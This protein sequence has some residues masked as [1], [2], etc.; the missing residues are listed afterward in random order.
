MGKFKE[1]DE[2]IITNKDS[3]AEIQSLLSKGIIKNIAP[4]IYTPKLDDE[5]GELI[6]RNLF[7]IIS[8]KY[9]TAVIS[10]RSAFELSPFQGHIFASYNYTV[11]IPLP[12]VTISLLKG[13]GAI[14]GDMNILGATI[15]QQERALLENLEISRGNPSKCLSKEQIEEK[16]DM[17][18]MTRGEAYLNEIRDKARV[19]SQKL[20][21]Q[22]EFTILDSMI[23]AMLKTRTPKNLKSDVA[24][25]RV[26]NTPH[27][28]NRIKLFE[29][30]FVKL[31]NMSF[32][33][34]PDKNITP[35]SYRL[36]SFFESYFSNYIEGT[37]FPVDEAKKI[38]DTGIP[39]ATR[40]NDSHDILGTYKIVSDK[41]GL[42]RTP[43]DADEFILMLKERHKILLSSRV[44]LLP[45]TFKELTN[46][47]GNTVFVEPYLVD[48]TLRKGFEFYNAL[49]DPFSKAAFMMFMIA[50]VHPFN[51]GNG[52]ISRVF[53]NSELTKESQS[54][55]LITTFFR[56][57]Y[58]LALK[59][60]TN[61]HEP[62][63]YIRM[64][65]KAQIN[66]SQV[67][68]EDF[69]K[70][71]QF[72]NSKHAFEEPGSFIIP[73]NTYS[74]DK[75][76]SENKLQSQSDKEGITG[77]IEKENLAF[78]YI[79]I[80]DMPSLGRLQK[81]GFKPSELF[82]SDICQ[83]STFSDETK[84]T[85]LTILGVENPALRLNNE[86]KELNSPAKIKET[87]NKKVER[88]VDSNDK[89]L[90]ADLGNKK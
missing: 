4:E 47:A 52:R 26:N 56:D 29:K 57:D 8:A 37:K 71:V 23:G 48:G 61:Q 24:K 18:I 80:N 87:P 63:I 39:M 14:E 77:Q 15:S 10:H 78:S 64:L 38:I 5:P 21:M 40:V 17:F 16:L 50:E 2:I 76:K 60:L 1:Y 43:K 58:M 28:N 59:K 3:Y 81:E 79:K 35:V 41:S 75:E 54:K 45:G 90:G 46:M 53:M 85:A 68:G 83:S 7:Q 70:V 62:D 74:L 32:E 86:L 84:I 6:R 55:I 88:R 44:D 12:G 65:Q 31:Y 20:S 11:K 51:D 73:E 19:I 33:P 67:Q 66:S 27:D 36:F 9:S 42:S 13:H 82:I 34:V 69:L 25:A 22:T 72:L 30:L 89:T 49:K